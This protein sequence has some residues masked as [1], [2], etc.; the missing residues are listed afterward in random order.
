MA[1]CRSEEA[2]ERARQAGADAVVPLTGDVDSLTARFQDACNGKA[3]VVVDPVF[4]IA[5][6]AASR[7]LAEGGRLVNLGGASGDAAQLSSSVLR[8]KS[9]QVSGYTNNAL[10][11]EE[12]AAALTAVAGHAADGPARR[13]ARGAAARPRSPKHGGV[14]PLVRPASAWY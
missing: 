10:T 1:V 3:D 6:T 8:S 13:R 2:Q 12:R 11:P 5:A 14:R 4:G 7:V 9:L